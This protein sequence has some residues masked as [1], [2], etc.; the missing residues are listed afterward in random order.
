M[1]SYSEAKRLAKMCVDEEGNPPASHSPELA[2]YIGL[3]QVCATLAVADELKRLNEGRDQFHREVLEV[4]TAAKG[5]TTGDP[6]AGTMFSQDQQ[7]PS[8]AGSAKAS[9]QEGED[10]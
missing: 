1:S 2:Q 5:P 7:G 8:G 10:R 3:A 4:L 6:Y 9:Q